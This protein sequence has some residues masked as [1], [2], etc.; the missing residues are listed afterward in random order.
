MNME[1]LELP[2]LRPLARKNLSSIVRSLVLLAFLTSSPMPALAQGAAPVA[3]LTQHNDLARTGANLNETQLT[4]SNVN[5]NQFGLVVTRAV[6]DQIY[7]QPLVMTN[8]NIP[9]HGVHNIVIVATVNDAVYAFDAD[10]ASVIAPYWQVSFLGP[11]VVVPRNSDMT[12]PCG[13]YLDFSGKIG[14]VGTPVID[15]ATGTLYVV[16]RT[17]ENGSTYVQRLHALDVATG[18]ERPNSP[19]NI[20]ASVAG[21]GDGN[22]AGLITFD[23]HR[24]NQRPGLALV[25]G[26]VYICWAAHC[27]WSPYHG[28]VIGYDASSLQRVVVYNDTPNGYNGGIWMSGQ[29][30]AADPGGNLYLST[31]NGTVDTSGTINRGESLLKLTRSGATL[32]VATWFTPYNWMDLENGDVDLGSAGMLLIPG[33]PLALSGGK[34]GL[35]YLVN[36]DD[37]GGLTSSTTTNDNIVQSFFVASAYQQVHGGPVWWD[38]PNGSYCYVQVASDYLRQYKFDRS[39]SQFLLPSYAHSPALAASGQP[40]GILAISANGTNAGSG[41]VWASHNLVGDANQAVRPGILRAYDAQNVM[42]ELWNSEQLSARDSAGSF[43][44]FVAPTVANGKVYLASFSNRLN[45]YGLLPRPQVSVTL[46]EGQVV[47]SWTTNTYGTFAL[48][49]STNLSAGNWHD[50]TDTVVVTNG[51]N[52]VTLVA[53]NAAAFYRLKR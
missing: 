11:N 23:T 48:Q 24:Q 34:Q 18:A 21:S 10:D 28:W 8:V 1:T 30:P 32:T 39:T 33:T 40:G 50:S 37:M 53:T 29:A 9:N 13:T 27:D 4:V 7:A 49:Y 35:L 3:V 45:V 51:V 14:I 5:T 41:I 31:G 46:V 16:A 2:P 26:V 47:L 12:T 6:D 17:K 42:N 38:G 19:T 44:K 25:N 15:P 52:S 43:A 20:T 22:V 36:R